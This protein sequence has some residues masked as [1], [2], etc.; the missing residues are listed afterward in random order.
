MT[1]GYSDLDQRMSLVVNAAWESLAIVAEISVVTNSALVTVTSNIGLAR[2]AH[3]RGTVTIDTAVDFLASMR[4]TKW[5]IQGGKSVNR[6]SLRTI[7]GTLG[8]VVEVRAR[9]TLMT[10]ANDLLERERGQLGRFV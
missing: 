7:F 1:N 5:F 9:Q 6:V 3:A 2:L 4:I 8:A 10:D